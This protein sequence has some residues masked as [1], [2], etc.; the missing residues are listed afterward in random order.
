MQVVTSLAFVIA[1]VFVLAFV[2]KRVQGLRGGANG[3]VIVRGGLQ[4]GTR[5]KV[6]LIESCG[7]RVLIGV[8]PGSVRTLHVFDPAEIAALPAPAITEIPA[9]AFSEKLAALLPKRQ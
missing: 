5:E 7:R 4:V 8:A 6:V 9:N 3:N 1:I 2:L